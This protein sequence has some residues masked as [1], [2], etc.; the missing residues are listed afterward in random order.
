MQLFSGDATLFKKKHFFA[1]K[2]VKKMPSKVAH[3]WPKKID[4]LTK[5][6]PI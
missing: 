2:N 1:P 5:I 3:N 4:T 6:R